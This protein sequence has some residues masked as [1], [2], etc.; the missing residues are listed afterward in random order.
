[1][2]DSNAMRELAHISVDRYQRNGGGG[3]FKVYKNQKAADEARGFNEMTPWQQAIY[4]NNMLWRSAKDSAI[5][6][7]KWD[8]LWYTLD[9]D[10][11]GNVPF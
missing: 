7:F 4:R 8:C 1:M 5:A 6:G 10:G 9:K 3:A 2:F 11:D